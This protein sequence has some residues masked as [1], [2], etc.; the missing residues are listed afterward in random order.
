MRRFLAFALTLACAFAAHATPRTMRGAG[1]RGLP[2][3]KPIVAFSFRSVSSLPAC[4]AAESCVLDCY[5]D[6]D[7]WDCFDANGASVAVTQGTGTTFVNTPWGYAAEVKADAQ[8]PQI[9]AATME[10]LLPGGSAAFYS[11]AFS[12]FALTNPN[13]HAGAAGT[14]GVVSH[15]DPDSGTRIYSTVSQNGCS[16][17]GTGAS[18]SEPLASSTGYGKWQADICSVSAAG[19]ATVR[20]MA[21]EGTGAASNDSGANGNPMY[22]GRMD[23]ASGAGF[24]LNGMLARVRL[25]SK[26]LSAAERATLERQAFGAVGSGGIELTVTRAST[27]W[28]DAADGN[29]YALGSNTPRVHS[30]RGL[31][32]EGSRTN[33]LTYA[34]DFS[35]AAWTKVGTTGP[36]TPVVTANQATAPDGTLTADLID[37]KATTAEGDYSVVQQGAVAAATYSGS[38]Y[39]RTVSGSGTLYL[40]IKRSG[41]ATDLKSTA[42]AVT[43]TWSRCH[44][45]S[46]VVSATGALSLGPNSYDAAQPNAQ[47]ALSVY[48]WGAQLEAGAWSSSVILSAAVATQRVGDNIQAA[49]TGFPKSNIELCGTV[50]WPRSGA[51]NDGSGSMLFDTCGA[52]S[53]PP[54][55]Q[56]W[57]YY[58]AQ[59]SAY[60]DGRR[61][62][63]G[64]KAYS[65]A[66][67]TDTRLCARNAERKTHSCV[68][69]ACTTNAVDATTWGEGHSTPMRF[70]SYGVST[71]FLSGYIRDFTVTP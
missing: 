48:V 1:T 63:L 70:G 26:A 9:A 66:S 53:S 34:I 13:L 3:L 47:A 46:A 40:A 30:S 65:P 18:T 27:A 57:S 49:T 43:T 10:A 51:H 28:H 15:I 61:S 12:V 41:S 55:I 59:A 7:S 24:Y 56:L 58:A 11:G 25:Y 45:E 14:H 52:G 50:Y 17:W 21:T 8:A 38:V 2:M 29:V 67:A 6:A 19:A 42:C 16:H 64:S 39:L 69:G 68:N 20:S 37:F 60:A 32:I 62:N 71:I 31:L 35:N 4:N 22:F 5:A 44:V 36:M 23:P 54:G 33:S